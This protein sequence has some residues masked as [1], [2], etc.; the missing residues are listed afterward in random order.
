M[1]MV[2]TT[3]ISNLGSVDLRDPL[4]SKSNLS[5]DKDTKVAKEHAVPGVN[6]NGE[7]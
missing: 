5:V 7:D 6:G 1:E 3:W 2:L 4:V